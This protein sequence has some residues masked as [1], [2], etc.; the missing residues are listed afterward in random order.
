[1]INKQSD[2]NTEETKQTN[3]HTNKQTRQIMQQFDNTHI[4]TYI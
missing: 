1:M 4:I 3:I 2:S